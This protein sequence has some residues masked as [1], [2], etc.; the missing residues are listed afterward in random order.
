[1]T[2]GSGLEQTATDVRPIVAG[3]RRPLPTWLLVGGVMVSGLALFL[4]LDGK[5]RAAS[6]PAV[7]VR[8]AE[9]LATIAAPTPLYIPTYVSTQTPPPPPPPLPPATLYPAP[10]SAPVANPTT[11]PFVP[12]PET[13]PPPFQPFPPSPQPVQ[14]ASSAGEGSPTLVIDTTTGATTTSSVAGDTAAPSQTPEAV[15]TERLRRPSVTVVQGTLIPAVLET[16]LDSSRPG[17]VRAVVSRDIAGFDGSR[18]LIPRGSRLV[19]NYDADLADGQSRAFVEWTRLVRPDGVTIALASPAADLQ[20]RAGVP[21]R[22]N[23]H[24]LARF[25]SALL[26]TTLNLGGSALG[27]SIGGDSPVV[28]ALPGATQNVASANT[29]SSIRPTLRVAAGARVSVFVARDLE[30]ASGTPG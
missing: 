15:R 9:V 25:G 8:S 2:T 12:A 26:Q 28:V 1:M 7:T 5:R 3:G 13:S 24:F 29:G 10:P 30:F 4:A 18:V 16:A 22:V 27:R 11:T 23:T 20:G 17:Q 6:A 14:P 21:G 19:G